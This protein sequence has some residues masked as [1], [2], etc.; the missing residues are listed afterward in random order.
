MS[1]FTQDEEDEK[2]TSED[3]ADGV[4]CVEWEVSVLTF[5]LFLNPDTQIQKRLDDVDSPRDDQKDGYMALDW[6]VIHVN[7]TWW[8]KMKGGGGRREE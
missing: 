2:D 7:S 3:P 6:A 8:K 1:C 4:V 5:P